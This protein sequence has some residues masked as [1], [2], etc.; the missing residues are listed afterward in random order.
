[1]NAFYKAMHFDLPE[2]K[3]GWL[4]VIDTALPA[5]D[6]LPAR[7]SVAA[8]GRAPGESQPD[9]DGGGPPAA[10]GHLAGVNIGFSLPVPA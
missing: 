5:G 3:G 1:M 9:P 8:A 4:R 7:P 2:A 10:P 6:D